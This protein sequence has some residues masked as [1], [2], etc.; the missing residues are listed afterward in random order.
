MELV[1]LR[2]T[3]KGRLKHGTL[4]GLLVACWQS[5]RLIEQMAFCGKTSFLARGLLASCTAATEE[6][7]LAAV[8]GPVELAPPPAIPTATS[9]PSWTECILQS[10]HAGIADSA[11]E[12]REV[13]VWLFRSDTSAGFE[14]F[15]KHRHFGAGDDA[16]TCRSVDPDSSIQC[17]ECTRVI[18]GGVYGS[19]GVVVPAYPHESQATGCLSRNRIVEA[20]FDDDDNYDG[21]PTQEVALCNSH[22]GQ[23]DAVP[24]PDN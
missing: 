17:L 10:Q 19:I 15:L 16:A 3:R 14:K 8:G 5:Q 11:P 24:V 20:D 13:E 1:I 22:R 7:R 12:L 2:A 23:L 9:E 21:N 4:F 18:F 6:Q